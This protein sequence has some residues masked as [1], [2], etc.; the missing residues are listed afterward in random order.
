YR[1]LEDSGDEL[2]FKLIRP[3]RPLLLSDVLPVL[4]NMGLQVL[5][6]ESHLIR[7]ADGRAY[8]MHEF[9]LR[10]LA[11]GTVELDEVRRAFQDVFARVWSDRLESDRFNRLVLAAG[12]TA[13]EITVLRAYAKYMQQIGTP[14]SQAY[15]EQTLIANPAIARGL[16]RLFQARFDPALG[17]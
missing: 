6:E 13:R 11:R 12:L 4:E 1:R 14:F 5:S 9:G 15:V 2:R 8:A 16:V 3:E 17:D 7:A 10:P